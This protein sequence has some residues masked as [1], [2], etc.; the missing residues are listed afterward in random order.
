MKLYFILSLL[1]SL[2]NI[3]L[4][5]NEADNDNE[6]PLTINRKQTNPTCLTLH[7]DLGSEIKDLVFSILS[8]EQQRELD[9]D[10]PQIKNKNIICIGGNDEK[11]LHITFSSPKTVDCSRA[12]IRHKQGSEFAHVIIPYKKE[13]NKSRNRN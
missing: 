3:A 10:I 4:S 1:L 5:M 12:I 8:I 11:Y 6:Y 7:L 9:W 2:T 13:T